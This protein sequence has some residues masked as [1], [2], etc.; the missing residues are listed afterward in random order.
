VPTVK[1]EMVNPE[2]PWESDREIA[3]MNYLR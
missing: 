1:S 2:T 3:A